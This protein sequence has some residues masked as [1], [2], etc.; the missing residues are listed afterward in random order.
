MQGQPATINFTIN[1]TDIPGPARPGAPDVTRNS[2][3]P[4]YALDVSWNKPNNRGSRITDY[5]VH[6]RKDGETDWTN[7]PFNGT[8]TRTTIGS[9]ADGTTYQVQVRAISAEGRSSWSPT[10][11]GRTRK[12]QEESS[13]RP[14]PTPE[15][16]PVPTPVP[17]PG[18]TPP[19][20]T[21][22]PTPPPTLGPTPVPTPQPTPVPTA[23]PTPQPTPPTVTPPGPTP[24]PSGT[25]VPTP[26]PTPS[27]TGN[28]PPGAPGDENPP[29]STP[30]GGA[31]PPGSLKDPNESDDP[32]SPS[33]LAGPPSQ[34]KLA[35]GQTLSGLQQPPAPPAHFTSP[36]QLLSALP[37]RTMGAVVPPQDITSPAGATPEP[38]MAAAVENEDLNGLEAS[39]GMS[40]VT[41]TT[42]TTST[43]W[44][45]NASGRSTETQPSELG[46]TSRVWERLTVDYGLA[47]P[48]PW[49][50]MLLVLMAVA[51][52]I[53]VKRLWE[54]RRRTRWA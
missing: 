49:L 37:V 7:H 4:W 27:R 2:D 18:P 11:Q 39:P 53:V 15:P 14:E 43:G 21:P 34:P 22:G 28:P 45:T 54:R 23:Q 38:A 12:N 25:P 5:D 52:K 8:G 48:W 13:S 31:N 35:E 17:T 3:S 29:G 20:A 40:T 33:P 44:N 47:T 24:L 6:Y 46:Q 32:G 10:G 19:A 50:L 30:P 26:Q 9:L 36:R 42:T 41:T 1:V 51:M 16:T